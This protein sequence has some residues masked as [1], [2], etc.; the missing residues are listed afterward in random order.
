MVSELFGIDRPAGF[1]VANGLLFLF[2]L[3]CWAARVRPGRRGARALAWLWALVELA[4]GLGH[5]ALAI[6][7]R[8]YF[9]GVA[10]APLLIA[11]SLWLLLRLAR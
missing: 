10:T 5:V 6:M 7:A 8:D 2:G 9:P 4:N 11:A 3:W 1:A